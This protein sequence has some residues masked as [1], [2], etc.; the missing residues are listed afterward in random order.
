MFK[1]SMLNV[2]LFFLMVI[3]GVNL[4]FYQMRGIDD[5]N[6]IKRAHV[7]A[8]IYTPL[9]LSVQT[10]PD[11]RI[12]I[13]SLVLYDDKAYRELDNPVFDTQ[14]VEPVAV[15]QNKMFFK[16]DATRLLGKGLSNSAPK[17]RQVSLGYAC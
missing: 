14:T 5:H 2:M 1:Q 13:P 16:M 10:N 4:I 9:N 11:P 7:P 12:H 8:N 15:L 3:S 6:P 17:T